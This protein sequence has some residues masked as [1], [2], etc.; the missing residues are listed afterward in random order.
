MTVISFLRLNEKSGMGAADERETHGHTRVYDV[1]KKIHSL[2]DSASIGFSGSVA[3][4]NQIIE[5]VK[6]SIHPEDTTKEV[7]KKIEEA[8]LS[9]KNDDFEKGYLNRYGVKWDEVKRPGTLDEKLKERI[10]KAIDSP[11]EAGFPQFI[12]GIYNKENKE[13][14]IYNIDYPGIACKSINYSCFGSGRDRAEIVIG[15]Y[16]GR[17]EPEERENIRPYKGAKLLMDATQTSWKNVGVGGRTQLV[18]I[19]EKGCTDLGKEESNILN[20]V[21]HCEKTDKLKKEFVDDIFKNVIENGAK[22]KEIMKEL[23]KQMTKSELLRMFFIESL[24]L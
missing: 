5:S 1:A 9:I 18:H 15:D 11:W 24:H 23:S 13:F 7:V 10:F 21:L 17:L 19:T 4:G 16:I 14:N 22:T 6:S 8:Y 12:L 20:N 3:L 2:N